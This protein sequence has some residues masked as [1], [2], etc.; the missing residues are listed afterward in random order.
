MAMPMAGRK[1]TPLRKLTANAPI[2]IP[3]QQPNPPRSSAATAI[4]VGIQISV[5]WE[6]KTGNIRPSRPVTKYASARIKTR[7]ALW[8]GEEVVR[9]KLGSY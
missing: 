6:P 7:T 9:M 2:E 5:M 3:G 4:P 8:S 1:W